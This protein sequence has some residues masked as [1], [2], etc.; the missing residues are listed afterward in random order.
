VCQQREQ[1]HLLHS[2]RVLQA[3]QPHRGK[4]T[5]RGTPAF[6]WDGTS[7][8]TS[9]LRLGARGQCG[10]SDEAAGA[11]S[12]PSAERVQRL[13]TSERDVASGWPPAPHVKTTSVTWRY[14]VDRAIASVDHHQSYL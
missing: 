1:D 13:P 3:H 12:Q 2:R 14:R 10:R 6:H 5:S 4:G 8:C 7:A 9:C 11:C